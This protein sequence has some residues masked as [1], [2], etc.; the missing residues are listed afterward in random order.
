[1]KKSANS[2]SITTEENKARSIKQIIRPE[3]SEEMRNALFSVLTVNNQY[4]NARVE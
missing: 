3:V 4:K 1:M 2:D